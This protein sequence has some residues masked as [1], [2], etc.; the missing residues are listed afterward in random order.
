MWPLGISEGWLVALLSNSEG[1]GPMDEGQ[2]VPSG[3]GASYA[4]AHLIF[5]TGV[6]GVED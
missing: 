2:S 3:L 6:L 1:F 5:I 4:G